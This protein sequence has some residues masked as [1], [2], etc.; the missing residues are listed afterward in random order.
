MSRPRSQSRPSA[1]RA[2]DALPSASFTLRIPAQRLDQ[3]QLDAFC[4]LLDELQ[5]DQPTPAPDPHQHDPTT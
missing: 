2:P 5:R 4:E 3:R 1:T